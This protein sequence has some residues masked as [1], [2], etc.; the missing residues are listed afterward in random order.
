M[1]EKHLLRCVA[2]HLPPGRDEHGVSMYTIDVE[3][4]LEDGGLTFPVPCGKLKLQKGREGALHMT[5]FEWD[6]DKNEKNIRKHGISFEI[7]ARIFENP[8]LDIW[9]EKHSGINKYGE[10]EDRYIAIG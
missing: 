8:Y 6:E 4:R 2:I 10:M 5:R 3:K 9:D 7:V 1:T